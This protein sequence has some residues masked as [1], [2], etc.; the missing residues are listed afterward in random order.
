MNIKSCY[1]FLIVN[2][3]YSVF[4]IV[5][6][7]VRSSELAGNKAV[8]GGAK[9]LRRPIEPEKF[10][11]HLLCLLL[12]I[13]ALHALDIEQHVRGHRLHDAR[14]LTKDYGLIDFFGQI[15]PVAKQR[16]AAQQNDK[17]DD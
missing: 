9:E 2:D 6:F 17:P 16:V 11:Q 15:L 8:T 4:Y 5:A 13:I 7:A 14:L 3:S 10:V 1:K 12:G